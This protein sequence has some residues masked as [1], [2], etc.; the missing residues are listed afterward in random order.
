MDG[1]VFCMFLLSM[2]FINFSSHLYNIPI[3]NMSVDSSFAI[4][5]NFNFCTNLNDLEVMELS[6][7]QPTK[8]MSL[9]L[10]RLIKVIIT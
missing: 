9:E 3:A 7:L 4:S 6:S 5:W 2:F 1:E 10:R 8:N